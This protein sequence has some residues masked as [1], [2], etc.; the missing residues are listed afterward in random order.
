[1][2]RL[3]ELVPLGLLV[4]VNLFFLLF[5]SSCRRAASLV[6]RI[7]LELLLASAEPSIVMDDSRLVATWLARLRETQTRE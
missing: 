3:W 1:M 5:D 7:D 4:M 2:R 6:L